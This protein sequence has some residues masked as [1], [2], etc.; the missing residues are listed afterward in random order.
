MGA[1]G[2]VGGL[3]R[4]VGFQPTGPLRWAG[5]PTPQMGIEAA[6]AAGMKTVWVPAE[7]SAELSA[8]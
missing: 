3:S 6:E 1:R 7:L 2:V 8:G 4:G 5:K